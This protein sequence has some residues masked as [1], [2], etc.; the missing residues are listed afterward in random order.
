MTQPTL[1]YTDSDISLCWDGSPYAFVVRPGTAHK[2]LMYYTGGG[3]CWEFPAFPLG[4][5]EPYAENCRNSLEDLDRGV[6]GAGALD[7]TD[8]R[9]FFKNYTLVSQPYCS[10]GLF[11]ANTT[12]VSEGKTYYQYG[13]NNA[14]FARSWVVAQLADQ[15][16]LE[17]LV[18]MGSSGGAMGAAFWSDTVLSTIR[19]EKASV[20]MDSAVGLLPDGVMGSVAKTSGIC[21]T[22]AMQRLPEN[23]R[24]D[25]EEEKF[26]LHE[27]LDFTID[28]FPHVAF[29][30][31]QPKGDIV[32]RLF[33]SKVA[34]TFRQRPHFLFAKTKFNRASNEVFKKHNKH[35]N[36]IVYLVDGIWHTFAGSSHWYK[37]TTATS[38]G[39]IRPRWKLS[40]LKW[41]E[42]L[43]KHDKVKSQCHGW[44]VRRVFG[45]RFCDKKLFPKTLQT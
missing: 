5:P 40:L 36:Y 38:E 11:A 20:I 26:S 39:L 32:Q 44:T 41:A 7:F 4:N 25:C 27:M 17:S 22:P 3:A 19:Y 31:I 14:E 30:H 16:P 1:V 33:Y 43:V 24:R 35:Q 6:Y 2:L 23:F 45:A 21:E 29:G 42:K 37:A 13:Y 34:L 15:P 28:K 9:N 12:V 18:M 8:D 10:G